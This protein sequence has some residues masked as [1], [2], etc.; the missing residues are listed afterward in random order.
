MPP[1]SSLFAD[2]PVPAPPPMIGSPRAIWALK[3]C[4]MAVRELSTN[5][6]PCDSCVQTASFCWPWG[7]TPAAGD[8]FCLLGYL[9]CRRCFVPEIG[10]LRVPP[11]SRRREH[12]DQT[13][14]R[15]LRELGIVDVQIQL[16]DHTRREPCL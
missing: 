7:P 16:R 5:W 1:S 9:R 10:Y 11:L 8:L 15:G 12:G 4:R 2:R 13:L 3:R 14:R 6:P